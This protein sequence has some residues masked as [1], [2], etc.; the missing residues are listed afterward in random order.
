MKIA[1]IKWV[2]SALHGTG[3]IKGDDPLLKPIE[4]FSCGLL[5]NQD[6]DGITIATDYWGNNEWRNCATIYRKQI[7]HL[8]IKKIK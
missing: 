7:K 1:I 8:T 3:T 2:D 5:V 6:K 4:G